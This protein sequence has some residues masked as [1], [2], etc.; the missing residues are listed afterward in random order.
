MCQKLRLVKRPFRSRSKQCVL[1][2]L[3]TT[4][5]FFRN[6]TFLFFKIESWN[7]QHLFEN[8]FHETSQN[9]NSFSSFRQFLFPFFLS[10]VFELSIFVVFVFEITALYQP[11]RASSLI[12]IAHFR[13]TINFDKNHLLL[14]WGHAQMTK[15]RMKYFLGSWSKCSSKV[16]VSMSMRK[17]S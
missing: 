5:N 17:L 14:A 8:K 16:C 15:L 6:K 3:E 1:A 12:E 13:T 7:F 4:A 9:F 2:Y 10:V 11:K